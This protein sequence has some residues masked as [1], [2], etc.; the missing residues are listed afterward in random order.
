M[1]VTN[2][3]RATA[4]GIVISNTLPAGTVFA[5][6]SAS[7]G[8]ATTPVVGSNGTVTV[9]IGSLAKGATATISVVVTVTAPSDTVLTD[10]ATVSATTQD[11]ITG[12]NSA[13]KK[14][15]VK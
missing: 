11:L 1:K 9:N 5:S 3:G 15:T 4:N 13:T 10:T 12:N 7:Q 14:T 8:T 6:I 2:A